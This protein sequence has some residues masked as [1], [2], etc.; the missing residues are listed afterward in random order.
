MS[1]PDL[2]TNSEPFDFQWHAR[3][4]ACAR[5]ECEAGQWNTQ[6]VRSAFWRFYFNEQGGHEIELEGEGDGAR[7]RF[8]IPAKTPVLIPAGVAF[9]CFSPGA[10]PH[11]YVHFDVLGPP[12]TALLRAFPAPL[13]LKSS[14]DWTE[15]VRFLSSSVALCS[16]DAPDSLRRPRDVVGELG[17]KALVFAALAE[18][19]AALGEGELSGLR[20]DSLALSPVKAALE[21]IEARPDVAWTNAQLAR[22]CGYSEDGFI[23]LFRRLAGQTPA[24]Y[25]LERRLNR[26][27]QLLC[28]SDLP[29]EQIATGCGFA[30]RFHFS[31]AFASRWNTTPAR[32]RRARHV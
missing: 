29:I 3:L 26:A 23:R 1:I 8:P 5:L 6:R 28:F 22:K 14:P 21:A 10:T 24:Q 31:R 18:A 2:A 7:V 13:A 9:N 25:A 11:F 15:R 27:A 19:V 30:D 20:R 12:P 32:F 4:F 17:V 16:L